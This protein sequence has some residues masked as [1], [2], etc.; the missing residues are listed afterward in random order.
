MGLLV[1]LGG[2]Q[3]WR[4]ARPHGGVVSGRAERKLQ[5]LPL[6][7]ERLGGQGNQEVGREAQVFM[8]C[9]LFQ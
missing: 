1:L 8:I 2:G 4:R 9:R 5:G 6:A 3:S 7:I